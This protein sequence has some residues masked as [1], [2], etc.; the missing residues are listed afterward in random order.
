MKQVFKDKIDSYDRENVVYDRHATLFNSEN[1]VS[2][3]KVLVDTAY[4]EIQQIALIQ[5]E[6]GD[7]LVEDKLEKKAEMAKLVIKFALRGKVKA[8]ALGMTTLWKGLDKVV[9]YISKASDEAALLRAKNLRKLMNDNLTVLTNITTGNITTIDDAIAA[10]QAAKPMPQDHVEYR[11]T[12]GTDPLAAK[13]KEM[14]ELVEALYDLLVSYFGETDSEAVAEFRQAMQIINTG[15]RHTSVV[16]TFLAF[17]DNSVI[18]T[19]VLKSL[20]YEKSARTDSEGVAAIVKIKPGKDKKFSAE[21]SGRITAL[22]TLH[23]KS[24]KEN[25]KTVVL[26]KT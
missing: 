2:D 15:V 26:K 19:G 1:E 24:G 3:Q 8:K 17:E 22:F 13:I 10:F 20:D 6:E 5:G 4:G 16:V 7:G 25:L 18:G 9:T 11:K 14:D 12:Y 23:V 21:A